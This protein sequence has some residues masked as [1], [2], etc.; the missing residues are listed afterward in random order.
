MKVFIMHRIFDISMLSLDVDRNL[1]LKNLDAT[2]NA[3]EKS[4][5]I[6]NLITEHNKNALCKTQR[7]TWDKVAQISVMSAIFVQKRTLGIFW[8]SEGI[9]STK[10]A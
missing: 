6:Q 5:D 4:A 10:V 1:Y 9:F 8:R 7:I 2:I 3:V